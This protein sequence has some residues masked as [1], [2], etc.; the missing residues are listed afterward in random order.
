MKNSAFENYPDKFLIKVCKH[1]IKSNINFDSLD[2]LYNGLRFFTNS[3]SDNEPTATDVSF[4]KNLYRLNETI[5]NSTSTE[6]RLNKPQFKTYNVPYSFIE[7]FTMKYFMEREISCYGDP[8]E[9]GEILDDA[10]KESEMF[11][12]DGNEID[13]DIIHSEYS[14][15]DIDNDNINEV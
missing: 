7:E 5:L 6:I 9:A 4:I 14:G 13:K 3:I 10:F 11:L 12:D 8:T 15:W 2:D 1:L